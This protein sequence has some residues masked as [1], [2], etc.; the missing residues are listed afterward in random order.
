M[1]NDNPCADRLGYCLG[2]SVAENAYPSMS[3]MIFIL[4]SAEEPV[5]QAE[6]LIARMAADGCAPE[7]TQR[8]CFKSFSK[9]LRAL[10][11]EPILSRLRAA[12]ADFLFHYKWSVQYPHHFGNYSLARSA[13]NLNA[14]LDPIFEAY[15]RDV[16]DYVENRLGTVLKS[17]GAGK[18][19]SGLTDRGVVSVQAV[20][21]QATTVEAAT[22]SYFDV[23]VPPDPTKL[24][25]D[26]GT[27]GRELIAALSD[28]QRTV[29][30]V[31]RGVKASFTPWTLP[32]GAGM[33]LDITLETGEGDA[34]PTQIGASDPNEHALD[35]VA[36]HTVDTKIR[37]AP[38]RLFEV[39]TFSQEVYHPQLPGTVPVIGHVWDYAFGGV[40]GL[41]GLFKWRRKPIPMAHRSMMLVN[42]TVVPTAMD[43]GLGVRFRSDRNQER[44]RLITPG[45]QWRDWHLSMHRCLITSP[46]ADDMNSC[47][48]QQAKKLAKDAAGS[49][50]EQK[51]FT[52][53]ASN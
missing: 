34:P 20:G 50:P 15:N 45:H 35:R 25:G 36:K 43:L 18:R 33:E 3:K 14:L 12:T 52:E 53:L 47:I 23:T 30:E 19:F 2:Y 48:D 41:N 9:A 16:G 49:E 11:T 42:A 22:A 28:Q 13:E 44:H 26:V 39:S 24:L 5:P 46:S 21:G 37:V 32:T 31:R 4:A 10:L 38:L 51:A 7:D 27:K 29:V 1:G 40:P 17:A 8:L 6:H